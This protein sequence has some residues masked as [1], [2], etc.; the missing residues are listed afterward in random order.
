MNLHMMDISYKWSH[1]IYDLLC[2]T[3]F[4]SHNVFK[5]HL[6]C[7]IYSYQPVCSC[8]QSFP[9]FPVSVPLLLLVFCTSQTQSSSVP[10]IL[11]V[12]FFQYFTFPTASQSPSFLFLTIDSELTHYLT[13][14]INCQFLNGYKSPKVSFHFLFSFLTSRKI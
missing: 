6:C 12:P 1:T 4:T 13:G 10:A 3:S 8:P 7:S 14:N 2:M 11:L 9:S 5:F